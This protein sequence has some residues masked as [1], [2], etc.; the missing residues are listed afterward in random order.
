MLTVEV[1][2]TSDSVTLH[3]QQQKFCANGDNSSE[4]QWLVPV[5]V[6]TQSRDTP[7]T[8]LLEGREGQIVLEGARP[9]DWIKVNPKQI[10]VFHY[11]LDSRLIS[12]AF[13][14]RSVKTKIQQCGQY[15]CFTNDN[16]GQF[17]LVH[18]SRITIFY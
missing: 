15:H 12:N 10:G 17:L 14:S 18:I 6:V 3:V 7:Q 4:Q 16:I 5:T 1:V 2:E 8:Y 13:E 11:Q 9:G